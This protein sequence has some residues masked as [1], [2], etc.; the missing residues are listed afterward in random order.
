MLIGGTSASGTVFKITGAGK[1][2]LRHAF[3]D[4]SDGVNPQASLIRP[5]EYSSHRRRTAILGT[6]VKNAVPYRHAGDKGTL[7]S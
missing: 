2:T 6:L 7:I 4:S 5:S 3:T 1:V